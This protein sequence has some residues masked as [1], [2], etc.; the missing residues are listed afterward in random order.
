MYRGLTTIKNK[1]TFSDNVDKESDLIIETSTNFFN[2]AWPGYY[3]LYI[4]AI[5]KAG[6]TSTT[7]DYIY[8]HD[9]DAPIITSTQD[10]YEFEVNESTFKSEDVFSNLTI[11]DNVTS[12]NNMTKEITDT[13]NSQYNI[14]N[15][16]QR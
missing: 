11:T 8:I 6:N 14:E 5:D 9:F 16:S 7:T 1:Y 10:H 2:G 4:E 15:Q 12:Y 3:Y 13:Y